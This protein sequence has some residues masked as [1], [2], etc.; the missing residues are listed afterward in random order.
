M[1]FTAPYQMLLVNGL[2][3]VVTFGSIAFY[4]WKLHRLP[5]YSFL[6]FVFSFLAIVS[7]FRSGV[8]ES[9]DMQVHVSWLMSFVESLKQGIWKPE[10]TPEMC[11]GYGCPTFQFTYQLPYYVASVFYFLTKSFTNSIKL[12]LG[13]SFLFSGFASFWLFQKFSSKPAA[14][15]AALIYQ[16]A[17]YHLISLHLRTTIGETLAFAIAPLVLMVCFNT[18][19]K[20]RWIDLILSILSVSAMILT[21][22]ALSLLLFVFLFYLVLLLSEN[23]KDFLI[24]ITVIIFIFSFSLL[25]TTYYWLP[26]LTEAQYIHQ[27]TLHEVQFPILDDF[28]YSKFGYGFLYQGGYGNLSSMVGYVQLVS[29]LVG[30]IFFFTLPQ[31]S[32]QK[33]Q[34]GILL[35]SFFSFFCF[36]QQQFS[37]IWTHLP[38]LN[39]FQSSH[40]VLFILTLISSF[41]ATICFDILQHTYYQVM[42]RL[43]QHKLFLPLFLSGLIMIPTI[44]NWQNRRML[45]AFT[46]DYLQAEL[47]H[48]GDYNLMPIWLEPYKSF[49][50]SADEP[51]ISK[52]PELTYSIEKNTIIDKT[53]RIQSSAPQLVKLR[54]A[55]FPG[56]IVKIN[57]QPVPLS[58]AESANS[59]I[60]HLKIPK[61]KSIIELSY[62]LTPIKQISRTISSIWLAIFC[63]SILVIYA[64]EQRTNTTPSSR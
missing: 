31:E 36:A 24:R 32:L 57:Q 8:Y 58:F 37:Y 5:S 16:F 4:S 38:I 64:T 14:F 19:K 59:G 26:A 1:H 35:I 55:F 62:Q 21:H 42:V 56:W 50:Y 45:T 11:G 29:V 41:I 33:K 49:Q 10:W 30:I 44:L 53:I 12:L 48:R 15:F 61:G 28:F 17:P 63:I 60:F 20:K 25:L 47:Y 7:M 40:R 27:S 13:G 23:G 51:L 2:S 54:Q 3:V 6:L 46:D 22:Q 18:V 52:Y 34:L 39:N 9:G 43:K